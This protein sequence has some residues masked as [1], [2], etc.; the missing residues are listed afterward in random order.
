MTS[1]EPTVLRGQLL[2]PGGLTAF[3]EAK[4]DEL[5]VL[6]EAFTKELEKAERVAVITDQPGKDARKLVGELADATALKDKG[7]KQKRETIS[8]IGGQWTVLCQDLWEVHCKALG[9][10]FATPELARAYFNYG[11]IPQRNA[12]RAEQRAAGKT[13]PAAA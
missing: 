6:F 5:P 4:N 3:N 10:Y 2:L 9:E 11:L 13:P 12:T 8:T 7:Q 1:T